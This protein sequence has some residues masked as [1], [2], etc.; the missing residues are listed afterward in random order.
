MSEQATDSWTG[1]LIYCLKG[2]C[3]RLFIDFKGRYTAIL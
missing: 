1:K 3:M 2:N